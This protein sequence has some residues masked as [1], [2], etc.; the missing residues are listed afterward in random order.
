[1][2][3]CRKI[4]EESEEDKGVAREQTHTVRWKVSVGHSE[5][6]EESNEASKKLKMKKQR[7]S[8]SKLFN[9]KEKNLINLLLLLGCVFF[10]TNLPIA[11]AKILLACGYKEENYFEEFVVLSNIL[12]VFFAASNFYLYCLFNVQVRQK[13]TI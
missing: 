7:K 1:M 3:S 11:L 9:K 8:R 2:S 13:V 5:C 12:E 6:N 4:T 10:I